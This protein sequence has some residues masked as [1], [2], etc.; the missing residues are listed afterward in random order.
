[1]AK[2]MRFVIAFWQMAKGYT[3]KQIA[4]T[5]YNITLTNGTL[6]I[7]KNGGNA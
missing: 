3:N 7:T 2:I 5:A 6:N 1:M 4:K